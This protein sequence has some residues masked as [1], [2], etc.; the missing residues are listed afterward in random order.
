MAVRYSYFNS[1][2]IDCDRWIDSWV[3]NL[4]QRIGDDLAFSWLGN[5]WIQS[6]IGLILTDD[7][8]IELNPCSSELE[9]SWILADLVPNESKV[10]MA[11]L[12][13]VKNWIVSS[14]VV[15][16]CR[17]ESKWIESK[18]LFRESKWI[19]NPKIGE[20]YRSDPYTSS[21][22][23]SWLFA[24]IVFMTSAHVV[25]DTRQRQSEFFAH[26]HK[27]LLVVWWN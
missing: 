6:W 19:E 16:Y 1:R 21:H 22:P 5:K 24:D 11:F 27:A 23:Y 13:A 26:I 18:P 17:K 14:C 9:L 20:S 10:E 8:R 4:Q 3:E 7:S 2:V 12:V 15:F 25:F